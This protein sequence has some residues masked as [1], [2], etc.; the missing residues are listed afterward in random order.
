MLSDTDLSFAG[1]LPLSVFNQLGDLLHQVA[2]EVDSAALILTEAVLVRTLIPARWQPQR[3]TLVVSQQISALLI[4]NT[5][6]DT[7]QSQSTWDT[8]LDHLHTHFTFNSEAI[9]NFA[10]GLSE[11]FDVNSH[12]HQNILQ[13]REII[14]PN[15]ASCQSKLTILLL[16]YLLPTISQYTTNQ[17]SL[18]PE[19]FTCKPVEDALTKQ[20][21]QEKLL[22]Q[23]T[24]QIRKSLDL[25]VIISTAI[26]QVREFLELDRLVI[27]KFIS[28]PIDNINNPF[29]SPNSQSQSQHFSHRSLDH[30]WFTQD[31]EHKGG[32]VIYESLGGESINS[33]LNSQEDCLA[34][35]SPCWQK[36]HQ[37]FILVVEDVEKTYML[38]NCLL[39]FL[40]T[41]QI[42]AKVVAPIIFENKLWG[43]LI[44]HQCHGPRQWT[45]SE[46]ALLS[47]IAEQLAIAINQSQL[48]DSLREAT[49]KLTQEKQTLEQRVIERTMALREA[50]LAAEAASRI[51]NE[52]LATISHELLTP[53]TY[54]IGMS[55]TLLRWPLGELT[56]R[57]REYLQTIHDSGERLLEMINDILD[58]SQIQAGK[59]VLNICEFSLTRLA[60]NI[61]NSLLEK[62]TN[63]KVI[64]KL[65]V[66]VNPR[67]DQFSADPGRIEQIIW[68]LLTNAIKFTPEGGT[69]TLRFWVEDNTVIFQVEDTG[70]GIP[71]EKLPLVF[72]KFQQVDASYRR[73]YEGTG[74]GLALTKQLVELHRG[75]IEVESTVGVGSIFT[76]WIPS[77]FFDK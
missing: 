61:V 70:I 65:D 41:N 24:T 12:T 17:H 40:R 32:C 75:R 50:L 10:T 37:G 76:V 53:L 26:T 54:V 60:E 7:Q 68:N 1:I 29:T 48:M 23:V 59:T 56:P 3:F 33:I 47:S 49:R 69:V 57:Q 36:Y 64:L 20:I 71:E 4:G 6:D 58:L 27:Y 73:P 43:L 35:H 5:Q 22:N 55:S 39:N 8:S 13:Y 9:A 14:V 28:S 46:K 42:R 25:P 63:A 77:S 18:T 52:F 66:Q 34:V 67:H 30:E 45:E 19:G 62:S 16:K 15:N 21:A 11:L 44:A 31:S 72:E 51:R 38:E 74:I 2:H